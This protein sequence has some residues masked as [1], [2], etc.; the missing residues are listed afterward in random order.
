MGGSCEL[1]IIKYNFNTNLPTTPEVSS[2]GARNKRGG[3][4]N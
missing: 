3:K 4:S 2:V 1:A